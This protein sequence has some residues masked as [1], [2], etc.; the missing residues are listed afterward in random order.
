MPHRA[1]DADHRRRTPSV[2]V[3]LARDG[4]P[5]PGADATAARVI[6]AMATARCRPGFLVRSTW[7]SCQR[8]RPPL[9]TDRHFGRDGATRQ[10][11]PVSSALS[12][13]SGP[14]DAAFVKID[15]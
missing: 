3:E 15:I 10:T 6:N 7:R 1:A 2:S 12:D 9:V 5:L 4:S 14:V 11:R 8:S 13:A